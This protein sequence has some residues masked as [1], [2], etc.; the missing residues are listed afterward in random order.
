MEH[1]LPPVSNPQE[2]RAELALVPAAIRADAV[3]EAWVAHLENTSAV[4][5]IKRFAVREYRNR[6]RFEQI[7]TDSDGE[8]AV[9]FIPVPQ[10]SQSSAAKRRNSLRKAG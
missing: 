6:K 9:P 5:A 10:K 8:I 1:D 2:L 4:A 3:L 7:P